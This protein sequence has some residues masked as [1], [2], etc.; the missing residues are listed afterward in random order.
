LY[1]NYDDADK[2]KL[3]TSWRATDDL[4]PGKIG[5]LVTEWYQLNG[6][7][8]SAGRKPVI[9]VWDADEEMCIQVLCTYDRKFPYG[10]NHQLLLSQWMSL[11]M[12]CLLVVS[13]GIYHLSIDECLQ[14][15][16]LLHFVEALVE[17]YLRNFL[18]LIVPN[19]RVVVLEVIC[20]YGIL[21]KLIQYSRL[22]LLKALLQP[23]KYITK[24]R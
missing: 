5:T 8:F 17:F 9:R 15:R 12:F 10:P 11:E 4:L 19:L 24:S 6:T 20:Y 16:L 22:N 1:R 23:F 14:T 7:I 18:M 21:E 3:L 2:V 13:M